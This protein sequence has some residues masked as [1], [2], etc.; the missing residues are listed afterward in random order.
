MES[1]LFGAF[2]NSVGVRAGVVCAVVNDI[3]EKSQI[4]YTPKQI[5]EFED[6]TIETVLSFIKQDYVI[7]VKDDE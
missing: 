7:E 6:N 4:E 5:T 3:M 2:C 1:L